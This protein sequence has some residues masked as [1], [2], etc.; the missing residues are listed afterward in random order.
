MGRFGKYVWLDEWV[1]DSTRRASAKPNPRGPSR[2]PKPPPTPTPTPA[3][4]REIGG[5]A[6]LQG[7][8]SRT[9][10]GTSR[11]QTTTSRTEQG[12]SRLQ[13]TTSRT[14]QGTSR[15][16]TTTSQTIEGIS[17]VA[18]SGTWSNISATL[19]D[20]G[21]GY[22]V[23]IGWSD[24][25]TP[26]EYDI[27]DTFYDNGETVSSFLY[28][29]T[30]A[31]SS[32]KTFLD[33]GVTENGTHTY[34]VTAYDVSTSP[35]AAPLLVPYYCVDEAFVSEVWSNVKGFERA[36]TRTEGISIEFDGSYWYEYT[37]SISGTIVGVPITVS[38]YSFPDSGSL[39]SP[40]NGA[41]GVS[42]SVVLRGSISDPDPGEL[43]DAIV[44]G[45]PANDASPF[46]MIV[47]T[48]IQ[49]YYAKA[50]FMLPVV[51]D[52]IVAQ[53]VAD[54]SIKYVLSEGDITDHNYDYEWWYGT[55]QFY[56][57]DGLVPWTIISGNHDKVGGLAL[58]MNHYF[59]PAHF[60]AGTFA[61][62]TDPTY[63]PDMGANYSTMSAGSLNWLLLNAGDLSHSGQRLFLQA[64]CDTYP[65]HKAILTTHGLLWDT[66]ILYPDE[67]NIF[68]DVVE[69]GENVFL[70]MC[71][72]RYG[73][74]QLTRKWGSERTVDMLMA[75]FQ[76]GTNGGDGYLR[77]LEFIPNDN[78][79]DF[80]TYSPYRDN[81]YVDADS[82]FSLDVAMGEGTV[83]TRS[84]SLSSGTTVQYEWTGLTPGQKYHWW[85][86]TLDETGRANDTEMRSFIA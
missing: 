1:C 34:N 86:R 51:F 50:N 18:T 30:V 9:E 54:P 40:A 62:Y 52:W 14:E 29:G 83:L 81:Y 66:G 59:P 17:N 67:K 3:T 82:Q 13:T 37:G 39:A 75:N 45:M 47:L 41:Y 85:I 15:L 53:A 23:R 68:T 63:G 43:L 48:D 2:T 6:R 73:E 19:V 80:K 74:K 20:T 57:L 78:R 33:V 71:G 28:P 8:T 58:K 64:A 70:A 69:G 11:L 42:A 77:I 32:L 5:K 56:R 61:A 72:H 38:E 22:D 12:T 26:L 27:R 55:N 25:Y 76:N 84:E 36:A 31:P 79:I 10:Q 49:K 7:T 65:N 4:T 21:T 24:T 35:D 60:S 46:K 16:Q 44:Y